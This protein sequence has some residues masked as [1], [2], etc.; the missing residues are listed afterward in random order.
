[1]SL[2]TLLLAGIRGE[3][4]LRAVRTAPNRR[5]VVASVGLVLLAIAILF[6]GFLAFFPFYEDQLF[7]VT[8][9]LL[10]LFMATIAYLLTAV[11]QLAFG[12]GSMDVIRLAYTA[13]Y[14]TLMLA[15]TLTLSLAAFHFLWGSVVGLVV[16]LLVLLT[17]IGWVSAFFRNS[18][19]ALHDVGEAPANSLGGLVA[20]AGCFG[21]LYIWI[22]LFASDL[23]FWDPMLFL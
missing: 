19:M 22:Q 11:M 23:L 9:P 13:D 18:W 7:L 5:M 21:G 16:I 14:A 20:A 4:A 17:G 15:L 1:M 12:S 6:V 3:S 10:P 8:V 2:V